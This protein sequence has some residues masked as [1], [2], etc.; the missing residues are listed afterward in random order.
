[1]K[2]G[3]DM[4]L[5]IAINLNEE[6]KNYLVT[7]IHELKKASTGG[8]FTHYENLHLTLVFL[9]EL[10]P[11]RVGEIKSAMNRTKGGP[12][13]LSI[14]GFGRFRRRGGDIHWAGIEQ[15]QEL[16]GIQKRLAAE[17]ENA[18][19]TLEDREYSPHLTLGREVRLSDPTAGI[20]GTLESEKKEMTVS[21]ISLMQSERING[22][23]TYTEIYGRDLV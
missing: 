6:I 7:A 23:L 19:F 22:K 9:G 1:M 3:I 12:F 10:N 4:R 8:N 18:G 14:S 20:Y 13:R 16:I 5:F 11:D 17:L 21:R 2:E 15:N